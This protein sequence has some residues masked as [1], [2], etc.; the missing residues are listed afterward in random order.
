MPAS[1]QQYIPSA[2]HAGRQGRDEC[3]SRAKASVYLNGMAADANRSL[4]A[5]MSI[6]SCH[7]I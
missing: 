1:M 4:P 7:I 5:V 3:C 2:L 6:D